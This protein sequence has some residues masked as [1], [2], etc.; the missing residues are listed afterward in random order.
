M[1]TGFV[2]NIMAASFVIGQ[3]E[4]RLSQRPLKRSESL[5]PLSLDPLRVTKSVSR[6][7]S[8]AGK[9]YQNPSQ[10]QNRFGLAFPLVI[11]RRLRIEQRKC[12]MSDFAFWLC[13]LERLFQP[14]FHR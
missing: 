1:C 10:T 4:N 12:T 5:S 8:G 14:V 2:H 13:Q 7:V 9:V 6:P 11:G 3:S